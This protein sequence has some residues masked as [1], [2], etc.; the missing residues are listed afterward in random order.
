[1]RNIKP[2]MSAGRIAGTV[3]AA[4][5]SATLIGGNV[6]YAQSTAPSPKPMPLLKAP[7]RVGAKAGG[8]TIVATRK[9]RGATTTASWSCSFN[10][11]YRYP[12]LGSFYVT[13]QIVDSCTGVTPAHITANIDTYQSIWGIVQI[14]QSSSENYNQPSLTLNS[15]GYCIDTCRTSL[16]TIGFASTFTLPAGYSFGSPTGGCSI[17]NASTMS[18]TSYAQF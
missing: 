12:P 15:T 9:H 11:S 17:V 4:A 13:S 18:C 3:G 6:A 16:I 2:V 1:M 10:P 7:V 8:F 14:G 5:L